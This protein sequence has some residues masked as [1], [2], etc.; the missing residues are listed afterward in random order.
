MSR[1]H[2]VEGEIARIE[3]ILAQGALLQ[4][5]PDGGA[6]LQARV[7]ELRSELQRVTELETLVAAASI[8]SDSTSDDKPAPEPAEAGMSS[9]GG[10]PAGGQEAST[11]PREDPA[12]LRDRRGD[13]DGDGSKAEGLLRDRQFQLEMGEKY[14]HQRVDVKAEIRRCLGGQ[15]SEDEL[16]RRLQDVDEK[17][18]LTFDETVKADREIADARRRQELQAMKRKNTPST[19]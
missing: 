17:F 13:K 12:A 16:A 18:F 6:K 11:A 10:S 15:L 1:K 14:R 5:L 3:N 9:D 2:S 8:V 7:R 4:R 19:R